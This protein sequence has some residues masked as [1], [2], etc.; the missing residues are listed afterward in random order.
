MYIVIMFL[1]LLVASVL[2]ILIGP[3]WQE[4]HKNKAARITKDYNDTH[5]V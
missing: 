1:L 2:V 4:R 5:F 3:F